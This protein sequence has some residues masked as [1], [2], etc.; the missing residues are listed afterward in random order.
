MA[1]FVNTFGYEPN[2]PTSIQGH[3][4]VEETPVPLNALVC[5][6][7]APKNTYD[8]GPKFPHCVLILSL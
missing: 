8:D 4:Q 6:A 7:N 1:V 3:T 2:A 5:V